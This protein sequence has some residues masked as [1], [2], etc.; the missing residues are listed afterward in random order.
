MRTGAPQLLST[1]G[2]RPSPVP[3]ESASIRGRVARRAAAGARPTAIAA[4]LGIAKLAVTF[5]LRNLGA[6][7]GRPCGGRRAI[8]ETLGRSGV[9]V[10]E[11][12]DLCISEVHLHGPNGAR[13]RLLDAKTEAGVREVRTSPAWS[14]PSRTT[15]G[16][17]AA[18]VIPSARTHTPPRT[19]VAT[20]ARANGSGRS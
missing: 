20:A 12:C 1:I 3:L 5:H 13:F 18:P 14:W 17:C 11:L 2:H 9:R 8:I 15:L 6:T 4:E 19:P 10:S 16:S 7:N